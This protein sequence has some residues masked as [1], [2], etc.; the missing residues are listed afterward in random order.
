M[1]GV[2]FA[3]IADSVA[4]I[5]VSLVLV[6]GWVP[7]R[8]RYPLALVSCG[9]AVLLA[10]LMAASG[11]PSWWRPASAVAIVISVVLLIAVAQRSMHRDSEG[12]GDSDGDGGLGRRPPDRP[13]HGGGPAGPSWW[14]EFERDLASYTAA[15]ARAE[16][17]RDRLRV[18]RAPKC[19]RYAAR[20]RATRDTDSCHPLRS[21]MSGR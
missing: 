2:G 9:C 21:A 5:A 18:A 19:R 20:N 17:Q 13:D 12:G 14:P 1:S 6:A 10:F 7:L 16:A 8:A 11:T 3:M 15:R 4:M